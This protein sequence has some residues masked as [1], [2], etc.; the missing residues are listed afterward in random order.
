MRRLWKGWRASVKILLVPPLARARS[1]LV[2]RYI[3]LSQQLPTVQ[4]STCL[5]ECKFYAQVADSPHAFRTP[6]STSRYLTKRR[7]PVKVEGLYLDEP[8]PRRRTSQLN[9]RPTPQRPPL[10]NAPLDRSGPENRPLLFSRLPPSFTRPQISGQLLLSFSVFRAHV[11]DKLPT[12]GRTR[13]A[14]VQL[15]GDENVT[16]LNAL[17]APPP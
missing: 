3:H 8:P 1:P 17:P 16:Y 4:F 12:A 15:N 6:P 10:P 13:A 5:A 2:Y 7:R 9:C 11:L 14:W